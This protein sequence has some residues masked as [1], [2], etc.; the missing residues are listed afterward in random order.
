VNLHLESLDLNTMTLQ[1]HVPLPTL[2][3]GGF[4]TFPFG[5]HTSDTTLRLQLAKSD[6]LQKGA[7]LQHNKHVA[8]SSRQQH[9]TIHP[10]ASKAFVVYTGSLAGVDRSFAHVHID[11]PDSSGNGNGSLAVRTVTAVIIDPVRGDVFHIRPSTS[12]S[13]S[14]NDDVQHEVFRET[15]LPSVPRQRR[16]DGKAFLPQ[17]LDVTML[18]PP[19]VSSDAPSPTRNRNPRQSFG[20]TST[21]GPAGFYNAG[22]GVED[23]SQGSMYVDKGDPVSA[24][25][26][27]PGRR[28]CNVAL[29]A[30]AAFMR[31]QRSTSNAVRTMLARFAIAAKLFK[32]T[33]LKPDG[34]NAIQVEL[35]I[36]RILL[37]EDEWLD[38]STHVTYLESFGV[39]NAAGGRDYSDVCLAHAFTHTDFEGGTI[40]LAWCIA[41]VRTAFSTLEHSLRIRIHDVAEVKALPSM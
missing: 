21:P 41:R 36:A 5:Q 22:A 17:D 6:L 19:D 9:S 1:L 10:L 14:T 25:S 24:S 11:L 38:N 35:R 20:A 7:T 15:D 4:N 3:H 31:N 12:T 26:Y 34:D 2:L 40:G 13:T 29:F 23:T 8:G 37:D 16:R 18:Q 33:P 39:K 30:D 27:I 28:V 32:E